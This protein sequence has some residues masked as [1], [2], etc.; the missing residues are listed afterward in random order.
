MIHPGPP[1]THTSVQTVVVLAVRRR[2]TTRR[3]LHR[4]ARILDVPEAAEHGASDAPTHNWR[5]QAQDAYFATFWERENG[6][7]H[8]KNR[9]TAKS[10]TDFELFGPVTRETMA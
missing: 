6:E 2:V 1:A 10:P 5:G 4:S 9:K 8:S 3:I 7:M